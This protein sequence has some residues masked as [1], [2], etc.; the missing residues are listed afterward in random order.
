MGHI[1]DPLLILTIL[2]T[3][4]AFLVNAAHY[5]LS[6]VG[7]GISVSITHSRV[8]HFG[9]SSPNHMALKALRTALTACLLPFRS[10]SSPGHFSLYFLPTFRLLE[11]RSPIMHCCDIKVN[12]PRFVNH[13]VGGVK[14]SIHPWQSGALAAGAFLVWLRPATL[15]QIAQVAVAR[16]R[17]TDN[18]VV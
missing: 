2:K 11:G 13:G 7:D 17:E 1:R 3:L 9:L 4:R 14:W 10:L 16:L 5:F 8:E 18:L 6:A 15:V 12:H